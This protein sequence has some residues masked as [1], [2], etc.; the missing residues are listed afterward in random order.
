MRQIVSD[1]FEGKAAW[2]T[3]RPAQVTALH[4]RGPAD[5]PDPVA[6]MVSEDK[7]RWAPAGT[8]SAG[9]NMSPAGEI[10]QILSYNALM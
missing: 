8:F 9:E 1:A 5:G 10:M 6:L 7:E 3:Q 4:M 2:V